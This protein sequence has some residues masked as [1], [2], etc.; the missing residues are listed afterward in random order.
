MENN[1]HTLIYEENG[2]QFSHTYFEYKEGDRY[3]KDYKIIY[4]QIRREYLSERESP[5]GMIDY[6]I[7]K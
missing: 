5:R 1:F 2:E 6:I 4:K 7:R 3:F